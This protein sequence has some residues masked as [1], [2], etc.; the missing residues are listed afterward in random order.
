M[1]DVRMGP[2]PVVRGA[3]SISMRA[4][5][6]GALA[7]QKNRLDDSLAGAGRCDALHDTLR[8]TRIPTKLMLR[9]RTGFSKIST[10]RGHRHAE[11]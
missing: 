10:M 8:C 4:P 9:A 6:K 2:G 5:L 3:R 11:F 7:L 1:T